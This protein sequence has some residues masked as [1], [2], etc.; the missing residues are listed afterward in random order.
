MKQTL[1]ILTEGKSGED[2]IKRFKD[3]N[4]KL[5]ICTDCAGDHL[6]TET[7]FSGNDV[8]Y[9]SCAKEAAWEADLLL[10][11]SGLASVPNIIPRVAEVATNKIVLLYLGAHPQQNQIIDKF[12]EGLPYS[13]LVLLAIED[14]ELM[15]QILQGPDKTMALT[16]LNELG[17]KH[18][19]N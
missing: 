19:L 5:L 11:D 17:F 16:Q 10:V 12:R 13:N 3:I 14:E 8:S 18:S 9:Q 2:W 4:C 6:E 1:A 7:K 15:V